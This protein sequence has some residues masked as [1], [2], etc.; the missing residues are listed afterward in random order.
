MFIIF[1]LKISIL[2]YGRNV[3][4]LVSIICHI[5]FAMQKRQRED[6]YRNPAIL[7]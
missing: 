7:G 4:L 5:V 1:I 6:R 3:Y 2:L